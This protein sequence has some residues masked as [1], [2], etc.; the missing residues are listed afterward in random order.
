MGK[1]SRNIKQILR[2][3]LNI[4]FFIVFKCNNYFCFK[5]YVLIYLNYIT[6]NLKNFKTEIIAEI[7]QSHKGSINLA[8]KMIELSSKAGADY[9]KFQAHYSKYESTLDE[10]FREGFEFKEKNRYAYWKKFEF[11]E[12]Q[13]MELIDYS[14]KN[15]I[16]FLCSPFSI[17]SFRLLRKIG[18]RE[19]KIGSGEFFS[20]DLLDE[21]IKKKDKIIL[22]TGL[23]TSHE[24]S[25]KIKLLKKNKI[26]FTLLQCTSKYPTT[27]KDI[28]INIMHQFK[29]KYNCDVGLSDHSGLIE[30][31]IYTISNSFKI[32]EVHVDLKNS[33]NPDTSSSL[34]FDQL[35]ILCDYRDNL[36]ILK[37][38]ELNKDKISKRISKLK[39]NFT[40]SIC[41]NKICK[42]GYIIKKKDLIMK[43]PG[44]GISYKNIEKIIGKKL[45][46]D[47]DDKRILKWS[48][49]E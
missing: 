6:M 2:I 40:K 5:I 21:I 25:K 24:I 11:T 8:K 20:D 18:L 22:S 31:G 37:N 46:K 28:G 10:N 13:W 33:K 16:K 26:N 9:V 7:A 14:K 48:D 17:Y 45:K 44:S 3:N 34:N 4:S 30:P 35:K 49:I 41:L 1:I 12:K 42:K 23:A 39:K 15:N 29:K 38:S 19:W 32:L 27:L 47:L 43:K 36:R